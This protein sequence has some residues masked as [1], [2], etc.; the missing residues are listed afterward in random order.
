MRKLNLKTP[1][2]IT[3]IIALGISFMAFTN[4]A[5]PPD[6]G[7]KNLK[8]LPKKITHEQLEAVMKGFNASL[9]VRCDFCHAPRADDPKK[10]D[11]PSDAKNEKSTARFML[12]MTAKLNKKYFD[13][14][15]KGD[16]PPR[17]TCFTCHNGKKEPGGM[18][19][20]PQGPPPPPPAPS[21]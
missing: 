17:V 12:K 1:F 11:F 20:M 10:L 9:G 4:S 2:L 15:P 14:K 18:P 3:A 6:E 19:P 7:F 16:K 5:P 13:W 8:V 21:N